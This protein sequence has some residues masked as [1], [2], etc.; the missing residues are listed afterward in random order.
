MN[1]YLATFIFWINDDSINL[2]MTKEF[3]KKQIKKTSVIGKYKVL[4]KNL[5]SKFNF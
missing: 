4:L 1:I 2:E 3:L 5:I